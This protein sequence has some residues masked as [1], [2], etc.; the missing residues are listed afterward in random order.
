MSYPVSTSIH[1]TFDA[2]YTTPVGHQVERIAKAGFR[3]LDFN[4]L[5][6]NRT[7]QSPFVGPDWERYVDEAGEAAAKNGAVFNQAHAPFHSSFPDEKQTKNRFQEIICA[8]RR[9]ALLGA[10]TIVVHPV[11]HLNYADEGA[12]Q[13]LFEMNMEFY[14]KLIPYCQEFGIRIAVENMWQYHPWPKITHSTCSTPQEMNHY[15]DT[16]NSQWI[17]GCLDVGH[18]SLVG[19]SPDEF[20]LAMGSNRLGALHVHDVSKTEDS[21]TIPYQGVIDWPKLMQALRKIGYQGDLT[22][23]ADGF[24]NK[25]PPELYPDALRLLARTGNLLMKEM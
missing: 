22:F 16:L 7:V 2:T 4:F 18:A 11:Q 5:D 23:E 12:P 13:L 1:L 6:L 9:A 25:T 20:V 10:K 15:L 14:G 8:L 19:Q 17:T 24:I 3:Y 21:H